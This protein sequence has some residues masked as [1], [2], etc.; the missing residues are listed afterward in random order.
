MYTSDSDMLWKR[1][2]MPLPSVE[3]A[4]R[5]STTRP[6][7]SVMVTSSST[8]YARMFFSVCASGRYPIAFAC[9][10]S[11]VRNFGCAT[12]ISA[13]ARSRIDL[14]NRYAIPNSVIT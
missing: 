10:K 12:S 4:G 11:P 2:R 3:T 9:S 1:S 7:F 5:S 6:S 8:G 14:P 13:I